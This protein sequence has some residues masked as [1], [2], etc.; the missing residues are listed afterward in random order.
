[1]FLST[2]D[3]QQVSAETDVECLTMDRNQFLYLLNDRPDII[4]KLIVCPF[5][6]I[7]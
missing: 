1:M 4:N 5:F 2:V 6:Q 7:L 3:T